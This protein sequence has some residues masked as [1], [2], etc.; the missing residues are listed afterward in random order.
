VGSVGVLVSQCLARR[1]GDVQT[2][3]HQITAWEHQRNL[4]GPTVKWHFT[5]AQAPRKLEFLYPDLARD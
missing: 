2:A 3:R 4:E 1:P 5:T